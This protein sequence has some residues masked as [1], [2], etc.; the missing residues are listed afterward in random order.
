LLCFTVCLLVQ[1]KFE[2]N[3]EHS[4]RLAA[5]QLELLVSTAS[6]LH[7]IQHPAQLQSSFSPIHVQF[8]AQNSFTTASVQHPTQLQSSIHYRLQ[9]N[10]ALW[11]FPY[12]CRPPMLIMAID[13]FW[14]IVA[15]ISSES[16][17][18]DVER[19]NVCLGP[20]ESFACFWRV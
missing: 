17:R 1:L 20:I 7:K 2:F 12:F 19:T 14:F 5:I 16:E 9:S 15:N 11:T 13:S 3:I 4:F 18:Q 6:T 10:L 8:S